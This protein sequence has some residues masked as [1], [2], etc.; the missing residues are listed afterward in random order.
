MAKRTGGSKQ[1][2]AAELSNLTDFDY[3]MQRFQSIHNARIKYVPDNPEDFRAMDFEYLERV[4]FYHGVACIWYD[5]VFRS[6]LCGKPT[7]FSD[8]DFWGNPRKWIAQGENGEYVDGLDTTNSVLVYDTLTAGGVMGGM[9]RPIIPF[10]QLRHVAEDLVQ[11]HNALRLNMRALH[12]PA[13]FTGTAQMQLTLQNMAREIDAGVPYIFIVQDAADGTRPE[14]LDVGARNFIATFSQSIA[15]EWA[16]GLTILGVDNVSIEKGARLNVPEVMANDEEISL[17]GLA[18][19][20]ARQQAFD[21]I[22]EL[23]GHSKVNA[24]WRGFMYEKA[25]PIENSDGGG[26][27][28]QTMEVEDNGS[29]DNPVV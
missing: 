12:F 28:F 19:K 3:Y 22:A 20:A 7:G 25:A 2:Q 13:V 23:T 24:G 15:N 21:K 9:R 16:E 26:G 11:A 27:D 14:V 4:L 17:V 10:C 1:V 29:S 8:W 6:Y 18:C 5:D